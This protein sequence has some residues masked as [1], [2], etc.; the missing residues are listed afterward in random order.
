MFI[1][2]LLIKTKKVDNSDVNK[3]SSID[4]I[5]KNSLTSS[6]SYYLSPELSS[7][8]WEGYKTMI[9]NWIDIGSISLSSGEIN[10]DKGNV[11]D[12]NVLIDMNSIKASKT[13][14]SSG[15][16]FLTKHLKSPDFFDVEKFPN[17]SFVLTKIEKIDDLNYNLTGKITI[18][19]ITKEM[20]FRASV[21]ESDDKVFLDSNIV[22]DRTLFD[23]R[24]GSTNFFDN[25]GDKAIG[26]EFKIHMNLVAV[27]K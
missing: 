9:P 12:G 7:I 4:A 15:E 18:K 16:D 25:L 6:G 14:S 8:V 23:V 1:V 27:K 10:I 3:K 17:S 21:Y 24:Y 11:V 5:I 22:I 26:N 19:G 13:G 20:T 2:S